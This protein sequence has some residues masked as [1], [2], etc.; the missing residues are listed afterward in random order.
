MC[1]NRRG[2]T[3]VEVVLALGIFSLTAMGIVSGLSQSYAID[4]DLSEKVEAQNFAR[5]IMEEL[6]IESYDVVTFEDMI[7]NY[8]NT[9]IASNENNNLVATLRIEKVMPASG[10]ATLVRIQVTVA[11]PGGDEQLARIVTLRSQ[12]KAPSSAWLS[13]T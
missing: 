13:N 8:D 9:Q 7:S 11:N 5:H 12:R 10:E 3:L 1:E 4:T 6:L 2:I